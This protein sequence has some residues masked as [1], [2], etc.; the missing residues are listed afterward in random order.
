MYGYPK[1]QHKIIFSTKKQSYIVDIYMINRTFYFL[2]KKE[3][4]EIEK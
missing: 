3:E 2:N 1:K 4:K